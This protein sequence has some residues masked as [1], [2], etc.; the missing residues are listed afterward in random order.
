MKNA[1]RLLSCVLLIEHAQSAR[2]QIFEVAESSITNQQKTMTEGR[3][4]SKALVQAYLDR[5]AAFDY[6]GTRLNALITLCARDAFQV[7]K[8]RSRRGDDR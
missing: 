7:R 5:I 8:L 6:R 4:K 2:A 1:G 3:V